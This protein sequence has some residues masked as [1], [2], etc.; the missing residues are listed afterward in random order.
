MTTKF[1]ELFENTVDSVMTKIYEN[2]MEAVGP[3]AVTE[4]SVEEVSEGIKHMIPYVNPINLLATEFDNLDSEEKS[5][6]VTA[7]TT[8]WFVD[9]QKLVNN[10]NDDIS[11]EPS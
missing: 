4:I 9:F 5:D 7:W 2:R 6:L 11:E 3:D 1:D 8:A 10:M